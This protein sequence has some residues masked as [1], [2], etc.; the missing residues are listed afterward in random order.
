MAR[1]TPPSPEIT[2][3]KDGFEGH[4]KL[5][6]EKTGDRLSDLVE[7]IEEPMVIALDGGWGTGKSHFLKCWVGHHLQREGNTS[8]TVYFDAFANDFMD[9]PL[10]SLLAC[11]ADV[12]E[13]HLEAVEQNKMDRVKKV[14]WRLGP[15]AL[16]IG[17]SIATFGVTNHLGDLGDVV[18]E[19]IGAEVANSAEGFWK[20]AQERQSV[21]HEFHNALESL[22]VDK[23]GQSRKLIIVVDELDRC[24]PDYG[25]ALL[26]IIKHFFEVPN[27]HFILG[28]NVRELENSVR[29]RYGSGINAGLY[30]QKFVTVTMGLPSKVDQNTP[31]SDRY[32]EHVAPEMGIHKDRVS[33]VVGALECYKSRSEIGLRDIERITSIIALWPTSLGASTNYHVASTCTIFKI[34]HPDFYDKIRHGQA[35]LDDIGAYFLLQPDQNNTTT[36]HSAYVLWRAWAN[37]LA[38]TALND[39]SMNGFDLYHYRQNT[40]ILA[41]FL[42]ETLETI[43]IEG[44]A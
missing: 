26:E 43:S 25:L 38:P 4:D 19:G 20:Q 10:V 35:T 11:M 17:A 23:E 18:A 21:M 28:T 8:Q 33:L 3:Y 15:A 13:E 14:V 7:R 5:G 9:E 2:L 31:T 1:I 39:G 30:L 16:R 41:E 6:R 32:F 27:V 22:T 36:P 24:R 42:E 37:Y 12:F 29:A 34:R 44:L 40:K